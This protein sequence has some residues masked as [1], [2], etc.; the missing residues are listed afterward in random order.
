MNLQGF[1]T[2]ADNKC[3]SIF[4]LL[5]VELCQICLHCFH[6][7]GKSPAIW[8]FGGTGTLLIKMVLALDHMHSS[9]CAPRVPDRV[10]HPPFRRFSYSEVEINLN[11]K[12]K[13]VPST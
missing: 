1:R 5:F 4:I 2:N 8:S 12:L 9:D 13:Y 3:R 11:D 6:I 10:H 7:R